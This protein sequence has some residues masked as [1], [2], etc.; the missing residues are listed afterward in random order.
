M[1]LLPVA[2]SSAARITWPRSKVQS[3]AG[4]RRGRR[5]CLGLYALFLVGGHAA[6]CQHKACTLVQKIMAHAH[7]EVVPIRQLRPEVPN[8]VAAILQNMMAKNLASRCSTAEVVQSLEPH[9]AGN[10]LSGLFGGAKNDPPG[11]TECSKYSW[12]AFTREIL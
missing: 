4:R 2:R 7:E 3:T 6:L 8:E 9:C 12:T 1:M 5:I 10:N 11:H